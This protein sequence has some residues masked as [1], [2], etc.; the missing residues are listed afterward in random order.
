MFIFHFLASCRTTL[1]NWF[2]LIRPLKMVLTC[3][4]IKLNTNVSLF[5]LFWFFPHSL[6][7]AYFLQTPVYFVLLRSKWYCSISAVD[8]QNSVKFGTWQKDSDLFM[9]WWVNIH[10][11]KLRLIFKSKLFKLIKSLKS[12]FFELN[13]L[14]I[15]SHI[16]ITTEPREGHR[17]EKNGGRE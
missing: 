17:S 7:I 2:V 5:S 16:A 6:I 13:K 8:N 14:Q 9:S 1:F 10:F 11:C 12:D 3:I 15:K 4:H